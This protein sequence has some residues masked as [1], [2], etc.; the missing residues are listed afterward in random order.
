[1]NAEELNA[2]VRIEFESM[3]LILQEVESIL[4]E[5]EQS[6]PTMRTKTAAGAY[7][8]QF[9]NG[10]ENLFNRIVRFNGIAIPS[11]EMWHVE[12]AKMFSS[13]SQHEN[14]FHLDPELYHRLSLYR[15]IRHVVRNSYGFELEWP[16][17][18]PALQ[19]FPETVCQL[20]NKIYSYL[21]SLK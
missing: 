1:M 2:F 17:L 6:E 5:T 21:Q 19:A 11:G 12:L 10:I 8:Y 4:A 3:D 14:L 7:L 13:D 16:K 15:K 9:Y 20:R 18:K